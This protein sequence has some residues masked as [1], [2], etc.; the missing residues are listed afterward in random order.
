MVFTI[1]L[2]FLSVDILDLGHEAEA[3]RQKVEGK[4]IRT[5]RE[6]GMKEETDREID[7]GTEKDTETGA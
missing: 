5:R 6:A 7:T 1:V 4:N 2:Y 3:V